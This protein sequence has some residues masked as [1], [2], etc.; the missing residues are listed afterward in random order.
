M[1]WFK[2]VWWELFPPVLKVKT[3]PKDPV[4][5]AA[6]PPGDPAA[7]KAPTVKPH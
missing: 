3:K 4:S 6:F 1:N 7:S 5:S 2:I